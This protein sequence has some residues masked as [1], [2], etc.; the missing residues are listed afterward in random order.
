[1]DYTQFL[2]ASLQ[3]RLAGIVI[4][5]IAAA[6]ID[7]VEPGAAVARYIHRTDDQLRIGDSIYSITDINRIFIVAAGKASIPMAKSLFKILGNDMYGGVVLTKPGSVSTS[8]WAIERINN[9]HKSPHAFS[10]TSASNIA[11]QADQAIQI[12]EAGHPI[13]DENGMEG[14]RLITDLLQSTTPQDLVII[15]ISGGASAMLVLP[16]EGITLADIQNLTGVLLACG[17]NIY[18][19]NTIRKHI[20]QLKGGQLA[21][22]ASPARIVGLIL[23][24][25]VGDS[26][27]VI[28]SGPTVADT[29]TYRDAFA[30]LERYDIVEQIPQSILHHLQR[31]ICGEVPETPKQG[32]PIFSNVHNQVIGSN[33]QA[34][35]AALSQAKAEGFNSL[36]LTTSLQGE[37]RQAGA[38]LASIVRQLALH[39]QPIP[40]PA[41]LIVGGETTVTVRGNG[42]GGRN[43]ELALAAVIELVG[44]PNVVL[45]AF[46]TDGSDGPCDAAGAV[47]TGESLQQAQNRGMDPADYLARNDAYHFFEPLGDLLKSGPTLTNVNDLILLFAY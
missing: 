22:I 32:D 40:R 7:A 43:Q 13:P 35:D 42:L 14:A 21:R 47:V 46:S 28:G 3:S 19:I 11:L 33:Q 25:V 9:Y 20:E 15:L 45:V 44:I 31:G 2:T 5:R 30:I 29:T 1:M 8:S 18:E 10:P 16:V 41:C 38:W 34:A 39:D 26:L 36:I 4:T 27:E 37:A 24:D 17:A 6:A 23:S 12:I